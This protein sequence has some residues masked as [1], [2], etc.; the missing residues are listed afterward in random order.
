MFVWRGVQKVKTI[1]HTNGHNVNL[2]NRE[3]WDNCGQCDIS[4][5]CVSCAD[6]EN[7]CG[8]D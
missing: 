2:D 3:D 4:T 7:S 6:R 8:V 1:G 5:K